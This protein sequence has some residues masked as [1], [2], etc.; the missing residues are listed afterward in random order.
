MAKDIAVGES[1]TYYGYEIY[2]E[3]EDEYCAKIYADNLS[4]AQNIIKRCMQGGIIE[5][6]VET[7]GRAKR[8]K[9]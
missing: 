5:W 7:A 3:K 6:P 9:A 8:R 4:Q 1:T 2:R